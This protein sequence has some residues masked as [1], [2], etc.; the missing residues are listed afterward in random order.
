MTPTW[1]TCV[2]ISNVKE[3]IIDMTMNSSGVRETSRVLKVC[4]NTVLLTLK[5]SRQSK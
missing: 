4:Y 5:N 3:Q 2:K 1:R